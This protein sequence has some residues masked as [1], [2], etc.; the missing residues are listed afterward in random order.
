MYTVVPSSF[1]VSFLHRLTEL[2]TN[3]RNY[4]VK[5]YVE[6]GTVIDLSRNQ[7]VKR[8]LADD[9][10]YIMMIDAD[11][12]L[13]VNAIDD[14]IDMNLDIVSGLYFAKGK[15]YY[16]VARIKKDKDDE[17]HHMLEEFEFGKV[18]KVAGAGMGCCLIKAKVFKDIKYPYFK[19][20]WKEDQ[21]GEPYQ[22]AEDLYFCENAGKAGYDI[23]LN[24]GIVCGHF[25]T[26]V[27]ASHFLVYKNQVEKDKA[28]REEVIEALMKLEGIS[29]EEVM[30]RFH[31]R[32]ALRETEW[33]K[34]DKTN[35]KAVED[36]YIN[37]KYEIYDQLHW[38]LNDRRS[39][40]K[41]MV[42]DVLR[43][44]P[45]KSTEILDYGAGS[46]DI[47]YLLAKEGYMVTVCEP[48]KKTNEF[49]SLRFL[50]NHVKVKR[51]S[52][53]VSPQYTNKY[54][55]ILCFDVLE[56][57]P[58]EKFKETIEV[59]KKFKKPGTQVL[60]TVSFGAQNVHP[61]HFDYTDEKKQLI[62]ELFE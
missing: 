54:D 51:I 47:A 21:Y 41:K 37:N 4:E 6:Q 20:E 46:G 7:L 29:E 10:D 53:P 44:Y 2:N 16:P 17:L 42:L 39:F 34:V 3:G 59:L 14:L 5:I 25:G 61:M 43:N 11:M 45:D 9:C 1:V 22:M 8:A 30:Q 32:F 62:E 56:H 28:N 50:K 49:M 13:P 36:Y 23:Y 18:M 27:D 60:S 26:E 12:V 57:I 19:F 58:D 33:N 40:D 24:T 15:P 31:D 52:Y 35:P 55:L 48:N 38:H